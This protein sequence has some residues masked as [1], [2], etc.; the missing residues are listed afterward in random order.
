[1]M[2]IAVE[3]GDT[4]LHEY[5]ES[6]DSNLVSCAEGKND[7]HEKMPARRTR[8]RTRRNRMAQRKKRGRRTNIRRS[9]NDVS[10]TVPLSQ[11]RGC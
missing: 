11:C 4:E 2:E 8:K 5:I 3:E 6:W 10:A 7:N 9:A 1:M